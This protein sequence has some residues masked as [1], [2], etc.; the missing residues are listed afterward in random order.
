MS[1]TWLRRA[2]GRVSSSDMPFKS[3]WR[4]RSSHASDVKI[5]PIV[6]MILHVS[7]S[8][9]LFRGPPQVAPQPEELVWAQGT[10][11]SHTCGIADIGLP[12]LHGRHA[13]PPCT[14]SRGGGLWPEFLHPEIQTSPTRK[15]VFLVVCKPYPPP[16]PPNNECK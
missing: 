13:A 16:G 2:L 14:Y 5:L 11:Q 7:V 6:N 12:G 10:Q 4:T 8:Y 1:N 15:N 9:M 3:H